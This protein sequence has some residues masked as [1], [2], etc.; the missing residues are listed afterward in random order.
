MNRPT[1]GSCVE[2]ATTASL[3]K[4]TGLTAATIDGT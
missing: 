4:A 3:V 1:P 2:I